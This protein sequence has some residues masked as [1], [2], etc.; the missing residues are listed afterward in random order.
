[1]YTQIIQKIKDAVRQRK[2][3]KIIYTELDGTNEGWRS[4]EPYS[5]HGGGVKAALF[6]W[7]RGKNGI[8]RFILERIQQ[9]EI[10]DETFNPR[11]QIEI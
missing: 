7:D 3:L 6:A 2:V 8:R 10:T 11:F 1:M 4:V 9:A 5:F